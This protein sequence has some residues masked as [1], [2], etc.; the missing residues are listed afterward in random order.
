[1]EAPQFIYLAIVMLGLGIGMGQHGKPKTG[2]HSFWDELV[3]A[4]IALSLLSWGGF[5][6]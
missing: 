6:A 5:F 3:G 2:R 1:M 4:L